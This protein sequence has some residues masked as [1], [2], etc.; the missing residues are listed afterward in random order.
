M[1]FNFGNT[2]RE[3]GALEDA[4]E[5][6]R[7]ATVLDPAHISAQTNLTVCLRDLGRLDEAIDVFDDVIARD[8]GYADARWNRALALLLA[9]DFTR[10]WPA[11]EWRWQATS[12]APRVYEQPLWDGAAPEWRTIFLHAEQGLDCLQFIRYAPLLAAKG[13]KV[14]VGCPPQLV[15]LLQSC[16]WIAEIVPQGAP[17][18]KFDLH[19]PLMSRPGLL[20]TAADRI[21]ADTPYLTGPKSVG[22]TLS[23]ALDAPTPGQSQRHQK[24]SFV[25]AGN[26]DH[27]NDH[28][29]F[30]TADYFARLSGIENIALFSLQKARSRMCLNN[31]PGRVRS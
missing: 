26:P 15:E 7:R 29:R 1:H 20:R 18:P 23:A 4:V 24:I 6:L 14:V 5:A 22:K 21:P 31:C 28:N 2:L 17:L 19:A 16:A 25:W 13:A 27:E 3:T 12:M 10:G 9:G 11:Y 30:C 8:P